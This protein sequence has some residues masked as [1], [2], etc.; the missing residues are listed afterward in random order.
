MRGGE[1]REKRRDD[2]DEG[3]KDR[4]GGK[5]NKRSFFS[6]LLHIQVGGAVSNNSV[7]KF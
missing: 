2:R 5:R 3:R 1:E 7:V 6:P 4:G